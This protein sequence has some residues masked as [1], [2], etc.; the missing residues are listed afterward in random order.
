MLKRALFLTLA[1]VATWAGEA[2]HLNIDDTFYEK[3]V[4][5]APNAKPVLVKDTD[6]ALGRYNLY[7]KKLDIKTL[8]RAHGHLCDGLVLA[9]VELS[10]TLPKLFADGV[11]DRTD[12]RVVA[13]NS[14]CLV[15][16]SGL[17]SGARINHRTLSLDNSLGGSFIVQKISTGET[18]K[19]ELA[20]TGFIKALKNKEKEIRTK[21]KKGEK[22]TPKDIDEVEAL[23]FEA[24]TYMLNTDPGKLLKITKLKDYQY[25]F[26]IDD[27]GSRSDVINKNVSR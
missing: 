20:D 13:K 25:E 15:D 27:I 14:P 12:L 19:V 22:I 17:M 8:A 5:N 10:N 6:G 21:Q 26:K 23:A 1:G 2:A 9:Y 3:S 24:M 16:T 4:K 18:Y 11:I 7:P